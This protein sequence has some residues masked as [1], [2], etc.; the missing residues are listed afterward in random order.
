MLVRVHDIVLYIVSQWYDNVCNL[1]LLQIPSNPFFELN[2]K[3]VA[4]LLN[5]PE[6]RM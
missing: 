4:L 5:V 3:S 2:T 1:L 6:V